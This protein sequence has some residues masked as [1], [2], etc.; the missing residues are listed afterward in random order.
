MVD[1]ACLYEGFNPALPLDPNDPVYV[2]WQPIV[3]GDDVKRQLENSI[4]LSK[5]AFT[6][7]L[8]TGLRGGGKTT[9]LRRVADSLRTRPSGQRFFVSFLDAD[10]T[11]DLDDVDPTDLVLAIVRQLVTDLRAA[12]ILLSAGNKLKAFWQSAAESLRTLGDTGVDIKASD[13]WGIV[14]LSTTLKRQPSIRRDVRKLLEGRMATLYDAINDELLAA[15]RKKLAEQGI[16]GVVVIVDQLDRMSP[17]GDRHRR[18]FLEGRGKLKA[19]NCH[20]VYTAPIEYAFSRASPTL[21][22]EYGEL[23]GLPLLPVSADDADVRARALSCMSAVA[24]ERI[25]RCGTTEAELFESPA[26]LHDVICLSGGHLRSLFL[27]MRTAIETSHLT[28]PLRADHVSHVVGRLAAKYLDPLEQPERE[29]ARLVHDTR[30]KPVGD[31]QLE[32]F[33]GLLRD[34]FIFSYAVG[35]RRWYDWNPLLSRSAL[36]HP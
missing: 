35:E 22:Q 11:L 21:E 6:H 33:Y 19:L 18:V 32:R 27:L 3:G 30:A 13:P 17:E 8:F 2:D 4:W 31:D 23:L 29:V 16:V 20:V 15:V 36:G 24:N 14:E 12:G 25:T 34:Q 5:N 28:A 9:E 10:D 7:R 26:V 1:F